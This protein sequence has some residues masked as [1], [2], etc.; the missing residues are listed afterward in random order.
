MKFK[1]NMVFKMSERK[2]T[3]YINDELITF[4]LIPMDWIKY[5]GFN[6]FIYA[7]KGTIL[8]VNS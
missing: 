2:V 7:E 1:I 4:S 6:F 3:W 8:K 5:G